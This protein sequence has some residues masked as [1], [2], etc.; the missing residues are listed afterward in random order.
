MNMCTKQRK[1]KNLSAFMRL[2]NSK[3][4]KILFKKTDILFWEELP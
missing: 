2:K 3:E 1:M 4:W